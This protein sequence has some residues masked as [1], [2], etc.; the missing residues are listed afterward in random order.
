MSDIVIFKDGS[1]AIDAKVEKESIWLSQKQIATLFGVQRPAIT[2]H[3]NNV[4]KSGEL[5]EKV[6]SSILEHTTRH[7]AIADKKQTKKTKLALVPTLH[8]GMHNDQNTI[9]NCFS[10]TK[11]VSMHSH[12]DRG[13]E[14]KANGE[15][16]FND[17]ALASLAL[18]VATSDPTQK[19][20]IIRL[21]ENMLYEEEL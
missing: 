13:N 9:G 3:L 8:V 4:F 12:E 17:N 18:L 1:I 14:I 20:I 2:K 7:G 15:A 11:N 19:E 21:I 5:D 6:V 10:V 16:K